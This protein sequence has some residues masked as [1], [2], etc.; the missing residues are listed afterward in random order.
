MSL[1]LLRTKKKRLQIGKKKQKIVT[2]KK[3]TSPL[4]IPALLYEVLKK[5]MNTQEG[6]KAL[7]PYKQKNMRST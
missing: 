5:D 6:F 2:T 4:R 7:P 1:L 3:K